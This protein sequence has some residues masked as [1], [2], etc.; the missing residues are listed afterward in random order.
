ME[1]GREVKPATSERSKIYKNITGKSFILFFLKKSRACVEGQIFKIFL[2]TKKQ[3][4]TE[5]K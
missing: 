4:R 5:R 3:L 2:Y 1:K